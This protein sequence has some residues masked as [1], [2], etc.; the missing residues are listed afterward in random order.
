MT[1]LLGWLP[2]TSASSYKHYFY[3]FLSERHLL[4][5]KLNEENRVSDV[6]QFSSAKVAPILPTVPLRLGV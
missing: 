5:T 3:V 2:R 4:N 1:R 6:F